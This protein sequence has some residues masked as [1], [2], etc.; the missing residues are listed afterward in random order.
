M[1][2]TTDIIFSTRRCSEISADLVLLPIPCVPASASG[3]SAIWTLQ[4]P[5]VQSPDSPECKI[6]SMCDFNHLP[7]CVVQF[8]SLHKRRCELE[9]CSITMATRCRQFLNTNTF[10]TCSAPNWVMV[11]VGRRMQCNFEASRSV[12]VK[13]GQAQSSRPYRASSPTRGAQ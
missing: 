8:F 5:E 6:T 13:A 7:R 10:K 1:Q 2:F 12:R 9:N 3:T 4:I 11:Y